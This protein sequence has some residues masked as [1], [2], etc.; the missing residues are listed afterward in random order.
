MGIKRH[1]LV[2]RQADRQWK[3]LISDNGIIDYALTTV[4]TTSCMI[5]S[6]SMEYSC[7]D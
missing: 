2:Q 6:A 7:Q 5:S 4:H 3:L 1:L